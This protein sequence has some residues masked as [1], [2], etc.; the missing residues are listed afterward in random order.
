M[1]GT[2]GKDS[3]FFAKMKAFGVRSSSLKPAGGME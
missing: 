1:K 3:P 2:I